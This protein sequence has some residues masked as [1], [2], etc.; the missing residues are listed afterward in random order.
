MQTET[1]DA[2]E[3]RERLHRIIDEMEDRRVVNLYEFFKGEIEKPKQ[4]L[5]KSLKKK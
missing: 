3:A 2:T 4:I 1:L 5:K